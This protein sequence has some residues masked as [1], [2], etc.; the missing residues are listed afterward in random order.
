[1]IF[2]RIGTCLVP[3]TLVF[4]RII[5]LILLWFGPDRHP[6]VKYGNI[7]TTVGG[8]IYLGFVTE[9]ATKYTENINLR[10]FCFDVYLQSYHYI[11]LDLRQFSVSLFTVTKCSHFKPANFKVNHLGDILHQPTNT[12]EDND[13]F[14]AWL[15]RNLDLHYDSHKQR[16]WNDN[17]CSSAVVTLVPLLNQH[18]LASFKAASRFES[19]AWLNCIPSNKIGKFIDND[20]HFADDDSA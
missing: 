5:V 4:L 17:Q 14:R 8:Q 20:T 15:D 16:N 7:P 18:R 10:N 9:A 12:P 19:G 11:T 2:Y 3:Q 6:Y 1:M 13:G